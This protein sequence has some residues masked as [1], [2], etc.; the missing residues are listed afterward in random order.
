MHRMS[1][2]S[3]D[4]LVIN[5]DDDDDDKN[6]TVDVR[7]VTEEPVI[8]NRAKVWMAL[9]TSKQAEAALVAEVCHSTQV[10]LVPEEIVEGRC[11]RIHFFQKFFFEFTLVLQVSCIRRPS[12]SW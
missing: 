6:Q 8:S 10:K 1:A 4:G 2:V 11:H 5:V 3:D 7:R 9:D 12:W